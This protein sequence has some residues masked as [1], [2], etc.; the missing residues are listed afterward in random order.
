MIIGFTQINAY[1]YNNILESTHALRYQAFI[2]RMAYDVPIWKAM[3]YDQYDNLS[4][5]YLVWRDKDNIVRGTCRLA[6]TDRPYMIK[7]IW[8]E[9]VTT[10]DLPSSP[11]VWE[12]S[13]LCVDNTLPANI[14]REI[15]SKLVCAYQQICLLNGIEFMVGVMPPN[16]WQHVFGKSGWEIEFIGPEITLDTGEVIIAGKMN[17]SKK[18]LANILKVTGLEKSPLHITDDLLNIVNAP[19]N[20][21]ENDMEAA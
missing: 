18:I 12:A 1:K 16:V 13:R 17:V 5:V 2:Q 19:E 3:E 11:F 9:I 4:T 14:R 6:P 10:I 15:I 20:V 7:D 21:R 8:P